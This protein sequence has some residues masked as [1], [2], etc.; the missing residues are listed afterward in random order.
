MEI[1][2]VHSIFSSD[3]LNLD[4]Y[5]MH[6]NQLTSTKIISLW[7]LKFQDFNYCINMIVFIIGAIILPS[8]FTFTVH[9]RSGWHSAPTSITPSTS[10]TNVVCGLSFSQSQPDFEGFLPPQNWLLVYSN[11]IECRTSL[12]TTFQ[13]VELPG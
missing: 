3:I 11:S 9:G 13:W 7:S 4:Y 5:F 1:E 6:H 10:T 8:I 12:K 2:R